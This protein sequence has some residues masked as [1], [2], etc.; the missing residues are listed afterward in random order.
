MSA[1]IIFVHDDPEFLEEAA[2]ALRLAGHKVATFREPMEA[3]CA[4]ETAPF[5][6]L[7]TRARFPIGQPN[8]VALARMSRM[9]QP[10]IELVFTVAAENAEYTEEFGETLTAPIDIPE[11]V[12]VVASVVSS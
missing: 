5:E 7:I 8:G 12:A 10:S 4:L 6:I 9:K 3:L 11:L 1:N 2:A